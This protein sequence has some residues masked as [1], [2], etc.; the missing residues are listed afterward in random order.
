M[1]FAVVL[2]DTIYFI[3][4]E[5]YVYEE[6]PVLTLPP[7]ATPKAGEGTIFIAGKIR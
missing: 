6:E 2:H 1:S 3:R 4:Y 5:D 7:T